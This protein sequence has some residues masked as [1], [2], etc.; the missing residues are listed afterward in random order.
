MAPGWAGEVDVCWI[1]HSRLEVGQVV[2]RL[3]LAASSH[4][5]PLL[6]DSLSLASFLSTKSSLFTLKV[7]EPL[8]LLLL[9]VSDSI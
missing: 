3:L 4:L 1:A 7:K 6:P 5:V 8:F 2:F 9:S